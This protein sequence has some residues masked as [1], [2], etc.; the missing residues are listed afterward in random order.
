M[1]RR[2]RLP[3]ESGGGGLPARANLM[4]PVRHL[5][6]RRSPTSHLQS[7]S[8]QRSISRPSHPTSTA[9]PLCA[10]RTSRRSRAPS[11]QI[12]SPIRPSR[13]SF[14]HPSYPLAPRLSYDLPAQ[15][16]ATYVTQDNAYY[17][18]VTNRFVSSEWAGEGG[19]QDV[20]AWPAVGTHMH[21]NPVLQ[22]RADQVARWVFGVSEKEEVPQFVSVHIRH[23]E[24]AL[25]NPLSKA[26]ILTNRDATMLAGD[27]LD[28][29]PKPPAPPSPSPDP[30]ISLPPESAA[31]PPTQSPPPLEQAKPTCLSGALFHAA[32]T[33]QQT[34][35]WRESGSSVRNVLFTTDDEDDN[36]LAVLEGE[37]GWRRVRE[38]VSLRVRAEWG[39]W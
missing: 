17:A 11:L 38:E 15:A 21:W 37:Y 7:S 13:A 16:H 22:A 3:L 34:T 35:L 29:C 10:H 12:Y 5:Q 2:V 24:C 4:L 8:G 32:V 30:Q 18:H 33:A 27:F 9:T 19:T 6:S 39:D 23:G 26:M 25:S 36:F 20:G 1:S 14:V 28:F 31:G